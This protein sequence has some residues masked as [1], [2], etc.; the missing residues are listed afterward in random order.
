MTEKNNIKGLTIICVITLL[1]AIGG[2]VFYFY[3][4]KH[5]MVENITNIQVSSGTLLAEY[6]D[7][8]NIN[9]T[10][11]DAGYVYTKQFIVSGDVKGSS[12]YNYNI[13][14]NVDTNEFEDGD[15]YYILESVNELKNG[16]SITISDEKQ[17]KKDEMLIDLGNG[18]FKG[19]TDDRTIHEY[20]LKLIYKGEVHKDSTL[21]GKINIM[22]AN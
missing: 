10:S 20:T 4:L 6:E 13:N 5:K 17:I 22:S 15:F 18:F 1:I 7:N 2:I 14:I 21:T 16:S 19:P 3:S 12:S 9:I 11:V 8:S